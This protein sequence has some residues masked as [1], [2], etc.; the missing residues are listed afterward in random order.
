M[1]VDAFIL[2][3][4]TGAG[5]GLIWTQ[6]PLKMKI[7]LME[8]KL[9]TRIICALGTYTL[10]GGTLTALFAAGFL[11]L[12]VGTVL[13]ILN[14]PKASANLQRVTNYLREMKQKVTDW[15][16]EACA[17]IPSPKGE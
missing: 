17:A 9:F 10:L 13:T 4:I 8:H 12:M 2:A 6:L 3:V 16:T 5:G 7:W 15:I 1:I 11:D 14:D